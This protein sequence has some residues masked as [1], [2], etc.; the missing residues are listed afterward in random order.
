MGKKSAF[1]LVELM[2]AVGIVGILVTIAFPRYQQFMVNSRRG[3]AKSNLSHLSSL[4]SAYRIDY[5]AYYNGDT[6]TS[7]N[8]IGYQDGHGNPGRCDVPSDDS[9]YG[10]G[11]Y[12]GF[13]PE[14]CDK[15]RYFY[16]LRDSGETV[17][18]SAASNAKGFWIYP[19]CHGGG[20]VEY[21]YPS[22][23]AVSMSVRDNKLVVRRNIT[24]YCPEASTG[25]INQPPCVC[26]NWRP[27]GG[28]QPP[29]SSR[30]VCQPL[31]Q[32]RSLTRTCSGYCPTS[33]TTS[34]TETRNV[35]GSNPV[36]ASTSLS[37]APCNCDPA[38]SP[39]TR[40]ACIG[41]TPCTCA[42]DTLTAWTP[43]VTT[44]QQ[45]AM[46]T[47]ECTEQTQDKT[48]WTCPVPPTCL[49]STISP[50]E[51]RK[52]W[53]GK[54]PGDESDTSICGAWS[55][56]GAEDG[57]VWTAGDWG[58]CVATSPGVCEQQQTQTRTCTS[59][60]TDTNPNACTYFPITYQTLQSRSRPCGCTDPT[61]RCSP[62]SSFSADV[63]IGVAERSCD[64]QGGIFGTTL[65]DPPDCSCTDRCE[66]SSPYCPECT[67]DY[68]EM[69][70]DGE[71]TFSKTRD[72][73]LTKPY[74]FN[75]TCTP[76]VQTGTFILYKSC[77]AD[78]YQ[79]ALAS[80]NGLLANADTK[81]CTNG[82]T[83]I[84]NCSCMEITAIEES[85]REKAASGAT[86]AAD[87]A[88]FLTDIKSEMLN[89]NMVAGCHKDVTTGDQ[90]GTPC[91]FAPANCC[92]VTNFLGGN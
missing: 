88:D 22:G 72:N 18:A 27:N 36:T 91:G 77:V 19:D 84:D 28:W 40:T 73:P 78:S 66:V 1:S 80:R 23:D 55:G 43:A 45:A 85:L 47:C 15:L 10:L 65:S 52:V 9:D 70:C 92:D 39:D 53:G 21:G 13:Q 61:L 38:F 31:P 29:Q 46:Y 64:M 76:A 14:A 41:V 82:G 63:K 33:L 11:N 8:G 42:S 4:Q 34:D 57:G 60:C 56:W 44:A 87:A 54:D 89:R 58:S 83:T 62:A 90:G 69:R 86:D 26:T 3:E 37:D 68:A 25:I 71:G 79:A 12:L 74:A 81:S 20:P 6:M 50:F 49:S 24:K 30:T 67:V 16:Q 32:T 2:V 17:V 7:N 51:T 48:S 35:N 75:C 5:Y 59:P